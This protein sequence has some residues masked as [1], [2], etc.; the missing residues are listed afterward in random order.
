MYTPCGALKSRWVDHNL[1]LLTPIEPSRRS[2][3]LKDAVV[4]QCAHKYIAS[5]SAIENR[6]RPPADETSPTTQSGS[7]LKT[8][9][10]SRF[11]EM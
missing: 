6:F 5:K 4:H 7:K 10:Y 2:E 3:S 9:W 11:G 1:A 8:P